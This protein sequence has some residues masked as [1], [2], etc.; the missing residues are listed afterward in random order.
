[1]KPYGLFLKAVYENEGIRGLFVAN[2][3]YSY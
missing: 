3:D 1:M 2:R